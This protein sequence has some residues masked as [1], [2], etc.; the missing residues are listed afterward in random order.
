MSRIMNSSRDLNSLILQHAEDYELAQ[1][2]MINEG[3]IATKLGLQGIPEMAEIII[4]ER[5]LT[6][7]ESIKCRYHIS[8]LSSAKSV[9]II[10]YQIFM[11]CIYK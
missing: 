11:W 5:D 2:G 4:I 9:E 1:K 3:I 7:L 8:Q 10:K 6:L